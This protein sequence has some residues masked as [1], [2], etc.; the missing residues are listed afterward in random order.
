MASQ[1]ATKTPVSR[2]LTVGEVG[3]RAGIASSAVRYYEDLGMLKSVRTPYGHRRYHNDVLRRIGFIRTAQLVGLSLNEIAEALASLPEE[4][5]PTAR[6]WEVLATSWQPRIDEQ[7]AVLQR[8]RDQLGDCIGCGCLSL[9][10]CGLWNPDDAAANE[11]G[12]GPHYLMRDDRPAGVRRAP[13]QAGARSAGPDPK[14]AK[15]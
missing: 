2:Q 12:R 4:R 3:L 1:K 6:D 10:S 13:V 7:I 9:E 8:L 11:W 5:T 15:S 14:T